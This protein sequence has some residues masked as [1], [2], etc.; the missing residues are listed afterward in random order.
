MQ[1]QEIGC[2]L[3]CMQHQEESGVPSTACNVKKTWVQPLLHA[4]LRRV[5]CSPNCMQC[6][7]ESGVAS[8]ACN[9]ERLADGSSQDGDPE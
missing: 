1:C 5:R 7:E 6:Q 2:T 3:N 9:V 8:T 4:M